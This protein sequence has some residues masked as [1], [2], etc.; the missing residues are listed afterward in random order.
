MGS[1]RESV[2]SDTAA[3]CGFWVTLDYTKIIIIPQRSRPSGFL[4]SRASVQRVFPQEIRRYKGNCEKDT[5]QSIILSKIVA[6]H[7]T[8]GRNTRFAPVLC[9]TY[10]NTYR[11]WRFTGSQWGKL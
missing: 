6:R 2:S 4:R 5:H 3:L 9:V 7:L 10:C 1:Y 11:S 8:T